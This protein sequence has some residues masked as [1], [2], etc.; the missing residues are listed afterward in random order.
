MYLFVLVIYIIYWSCIGH[1]LVVYIIIIIIII[2]IMLDRSF[3]PDSLQP[4]I[5][6]LC[7]TQFII[8]SLADLCP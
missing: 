4:L 5:Y 2:I 1:I 3:D 6:V 8:G 7:L